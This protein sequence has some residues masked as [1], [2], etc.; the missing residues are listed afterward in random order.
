VERG[1]GGG[2]GRFKA[3]LV[4]GREHKKLNV[5]IQKTFYSLA[6]LV[7]CCLEKWFDQ[8]IFLKT[9]IKINAGVKKRRIS[10]QIRKN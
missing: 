5:F 2:Y 6:D 8:R 4:N 9:M 3:Y 7:P 1:G 10:Q